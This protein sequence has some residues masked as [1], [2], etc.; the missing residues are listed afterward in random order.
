MYLKKMINRFKAPVHD[1]RIW[2]KDKIA[3][4]YGPGCPQNGKY[5]IKFILDVL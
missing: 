1:D 5:I 2:K 4:S 3:K